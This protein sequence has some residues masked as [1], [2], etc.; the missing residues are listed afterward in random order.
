MS[1]VDCRPCA[2][3]HDQVGSFSTPTLASRLLAD[4]GFILEL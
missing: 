2:M 4:F 3:V 1:L